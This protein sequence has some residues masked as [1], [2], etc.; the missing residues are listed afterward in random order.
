M[1]EHNKV[2]IEAKASCNERMDNK[3]ISTDITVYSLHSLSTQQT[4]IISEVRH[5]IKHLHYS[6]RHEELK[7]Y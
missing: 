7:F 6:R 1:R 3:K 4:T 5:A 2:Q